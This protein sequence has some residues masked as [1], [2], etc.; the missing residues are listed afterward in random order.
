MATKTTTRAH[1]NGTVGEEFIIPDLGDVATRPKKL[2]ETAAGAQVMLDVP[3]L[4]IRSLQLT[5]IGDS[6]LIVHRWSEKAKKEMLDKQMKKPQL[7]KE[8]KNPEEDYWQSMYILPDGSFGF[9]A[10]A[11][12][13]AAVTAVSLISGVT[14]IA[15]RGTFHIVGEY[16]VINGR[17][18]PREDMVRIAMGTA[19]IRYRAQYFPWSTT[20]TIRYNPYVMGPAQIANLM[21]HA[22]FGVGVG[23]W[24]AER[25]G[26][27]GLFHVASADELEA[28]L[29]RQLQELGDAARAENRERL[30]AMIAKDPNSVRGGGFNA[31]GGFAA[32]TPV[33]DVD[34]L[35]SLEELVSE[36]PEDGPEA[37]NAL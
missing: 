32:A 2:N 30:A 31:F 11:F 19:D 34:G 4:E 29:V 18:E 5:L 26:S 15:A 16:A 10:I 37:E 35:E 12:K 1:K 36:L 6:P 9:P 7:A 20:I 3:P 24:R 23:E 28:G 25:D 22:G 27:M 8:A 17:P 21:Q 13:S 14:K 33:G